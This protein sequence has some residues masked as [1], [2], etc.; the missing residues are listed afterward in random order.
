MANNLLQ[1]AQA[2]ST[3]VHNN[4][5]NLIL[6]AEQDKLDQTGFMY[7]DKSPAYIG[8]VDPVVENIAMGPL[9]TL[10]SLGSVGKKLLERAGLRNPVTHYTTGSGATEILKSGT[11]RGRDQAFP[12][13]PFRK[14]SKKAIDAK[15][16]EFRE[17]TLSSADELDFYA[18]EL[19]QGSPAVSVTRDPMFLS[20]PHAH[21]GSDIGLIMDRG[22]LVKQGMKIQPFAEAKYGKTLPY[23]HTQYGRMNPRFEFEERVRGYI[24]T[25]NI[26][27]IDLARLPLE[28]VDRYKTLIELSK[29]RTPIIKSFEAKESLQR[30]LNNIRRARLGRGK[31]LSQY[32]REQG[33]NTQDYIQATERLLNTPTYRFDPFSR[34]Q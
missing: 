12:G 3:N 27:L 16:K 18:N 33:V 1:M 29:S 24:P 26:R 2:A 25:E 22:Q 7:A 4:I 14:D 20:R 9:L 5:D 30:T 11:I 8:G 10:K 28:D 19:I 31:S 32:L 6:K 15:L 17:K 34:L 21:V 23:T 13:K